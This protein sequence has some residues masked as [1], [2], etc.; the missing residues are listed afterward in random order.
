VTGDER[1]VSWGRW[2]EAHEALAGRVTALESAAGKRK[3][4]TWTLILAVL[5]GLALPTIVILIG[6]ALHRALNG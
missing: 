2:Q 3:D 5:S 6:V 4:R 1:P